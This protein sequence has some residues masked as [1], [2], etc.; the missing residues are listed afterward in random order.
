MFRYMNRGREFYARVARLAVPLILQYLL[1]NTLSIVDSIIVGSLGETATASITLANIPLRV[2]MTFAF[3][4]QCGTSVLISQ[5]NG[6]GDTDSVNRATGVGLWFVVICTVLYSSVMFIA[7]YQFMGLF[8]NDA[9]VIAYSVDYGKWVALSYVFNIFDLIY[10]TLLRSVEKPTFGT[11]VLCSTTVLK[12]VLDYILVKGCFGIAPM[13]VF[14]AGLSTLI[15]RLVEFAAVL[16]HMFLSKDFQ[17]EPK[18][19]LMPGWDMVKRYF[20]TCGPI[21][22]NDTVWGV[23]ASAITN[24]MSH[25]SNS[26]AVLSAYSIASSVENM[27]NSLTSGGS[28][29]AAVIVGTEIGA[30][31]SNKTIKEYAYAIVTLFTGVGI[32]ASGLLI[33]IKYLVCPTFLYPLYGLSEDAQGICSMMITVGAFLVPMKAFNNAIASGVLR[34]GGDVKVGALIDT[35]PLCAGA[36]PYAYLMGFVFNA[37]P[38]W[39]YLAFI[40]QYVIQTFFGGWRLVSDSWIHDVTT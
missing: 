30:G 9:E 3:G 34:G 2:L 5:F 1:S 8:G 36:V 11:A 32:V 16:L 39:V 38:L 6:K 26:V 28:S 7:P 14:G 40:V 4:A 18:Y 33:L 29:V 15:T 25:M 35:L 20:V 24:V 12:I 13:G 23:G 10:I 19:L 21:I 27:I 22:L 37:G 31:R 17:L